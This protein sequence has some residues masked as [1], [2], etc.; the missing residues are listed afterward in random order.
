MVW[1]L[2]RITTERRR[3]RWE[4]RCECVNE[5][6]WYRFYVVLIEGRRRERRER[7]EGMS[8]RECVSYP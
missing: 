6:E 1:S 4:R 2:C 8:D 3:G 7:S 5:C